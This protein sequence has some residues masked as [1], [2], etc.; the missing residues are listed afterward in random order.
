MR[1]LGVDPGFAN[2]GWCVGSVHPRGIVIP[3]ECGVMHTTKSHKR[4][5]VL[6]PDDEFRRT[7]ELADKLERLL[8]EHDVRMV[9]AEGMSSPRNA[10]T[11]RMLGYAWGVLA[12]ACQRRTLPLAQVSPKQLKKALCGRISV[13]DAELHAQVQLRYPEYK[14]IVETFVTNSSKREHAYDA[15]GAIDACREGQLF[16][17][18]VA[19]LR[20]VA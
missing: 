8:D 12:S 18:L 7:T 15:L 9:F 5:K 2:F 14:A 1:V 6:A 20:D 13:T 11:I 10:T 17:T 16:R 4:L 19:N 3:V